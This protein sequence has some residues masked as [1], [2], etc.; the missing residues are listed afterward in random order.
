MRSTSTTTTLIAVTALALALPGCADGHGTPSRAKTSMAASLAPALLTA[1]ELPKGF[2][3][4]E[5][6]GPDGTGGGCPALDEDPQEESVAHARILFRQGELGP[7]IGEQ[8][9]RFPHGGAHRLVAR[10]RMTSHDCARFS[11]RHDLVGTVEFR[12][13]ALPTGT[14]GDESAAV[15]LTG[16][17]AGAPVGVMQDVLVVRNQDTDILLTHTGYGSLGPG[18]TESTA[19]K[20]LAALKERGGA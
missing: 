13:T 6:P 11:A 12:L 3:V 14:I 5:E 2:A 4:V 1:D 16:T 10:I 15:R 17:V 18:L 19:R 20:A 8:L 9:L 7:L